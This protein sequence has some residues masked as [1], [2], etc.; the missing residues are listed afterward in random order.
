VLF[1]H[2]SQKRAFTLIELLVVIAIISIL[3]GLLLPAVQKIR[4]AAQRMKCGNNL[5]QMGLAMHNYENTYGKL[6]PGLVNSGRSNNGGAAPPA[7]QSFY[8]ADGQ[9]VVYNHSGF[10]YLLPYIEQDNLYRNYVFTVPGSNS[11]PFSFT[12]P[13]TLT[14]THA[15]ALVQGTMV[16][17]YTCPADSI[18]PDVK[19]LGGTGAYSLIG[20]VRSNYLFSSGAYFDDMLPSANKTTVSNTFAGAFGHNSKTTLEDIRDGSSNTIAIGESIQNR[21]DD[22]AGPFWGSGSHAAT[23]G[24]TPFGSTNYNI[25]TPSAAG[26]NSPQRQRCVSPGQFG[27]MHTDGANFLYCDGSVKFL[28]NNIDYNSV[29]YPLNTK[30]GAEVIVMP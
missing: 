8:P 5:K 28:T 17:I 18:D 6:P 15:N 25:N 1:R 10:V 24:T 7:A 30:A 23:L 26:C 3:I 16:P 9:W 21:F 13:A 22:N 4:G 11:N 14:A 2:Q 27:S 12:M 19:V 29:F 20:T